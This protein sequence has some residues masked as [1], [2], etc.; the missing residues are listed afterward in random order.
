MSIFSKWEKIL[1]VIIVFISISMAIACVIPL[2]CRSAKEQNENKDT[3]KI[4]F[5]T[6]TPRENPNENLLF[7]AKAQIFEELSEISFA[8][9]IRVTGLD[10]KGQSELPEPFIRIDRFEKTALESLDI[11]VNGR[12]I[13][14]PDSVVA[15]KFLPPAAGAPEP[16][17]TLS[18]T[19]FWRNENLTPEQKSL[20]YW[21]EGAEKLTLARGNPDGTVS[22]TVPSE[23]TNSVLELQANLQ[24]GDVSV[25]EAKML[26]QSRNLSDIKKIAGKIRLL[27]GLKK[28]IETG[29]WKWRNP[30]GIPS[31][32][33][34]IKSAINGGIVKWYGLSDWNGVPVIDGSAVTWNGIVSSVKLVV[35]GKENLKRVLETLSALPLDD[36]FSL[37]IEKEGPDIEKK[38][39]D[40][41]E[42]KK[43]DDTE[44]ESSDI[45]EKTEKSFDIKEDSSGIE[46]E[47]SDI[48]KISIIDGFLINFSSL[49]GI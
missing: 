6:P 24:S 41:T 39:A 45:S 18:F 11:S 23:E 16:E 47:G 19:A 8:D 36:G 30:D 22:L 29:E 31:E 1:L 13:V 25:T 40:G 2:Y 12:R 10:A 7:S 48:T 33:K 21:H 20:K 38:K 37:N 49:W 3:S 43:A 5:E 27:C 26:F 32:K 28:P 17:H 46:E 35:A 15:E 44:E 14:S 34:S 42:E 9:D 4:I